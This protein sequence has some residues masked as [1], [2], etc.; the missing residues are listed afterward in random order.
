MHVRGSQ[1]QRL[2][3]VGQEEL[4]RA[5]MDL[6]Q[7]GYGDANLLGIELACCQSNVCY[8]DVYC[9]HNWSRDLFQKYPSASKLVLPVN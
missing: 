6:K 5:G 4:T 2:S 3:L 7:V 1:L 8:K 9:M